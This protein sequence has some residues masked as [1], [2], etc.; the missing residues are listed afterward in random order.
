[1]ATWGNVG[2]ESALPGRGVRR[3]ARRERDLPRPVCQTLQVDIGRALGLVSGSLCVMTAAFEHKRAGVLARRVMQCADEPACVLVA[4]PKGQRL[5]TLI[6]DSHAF[7]LNVIDPTQRL[8]IKKFQPEEEGDQFDM[9]ETR[10]L[11]TGAPA[12]L[13]AV[14]ALDCEVMRHFDLEA[15]HEVYVGQVLAALV[16][17]KGIE[18]CHSGEP[19]PAAQT[20]PGANARVGNGHAHPGAASIPGHDA[21]GQPVAQHG[22]RHP[23]E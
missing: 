19:A 10:T 14:A 6:R 20:I 3:D 11:A 15:D 23:G 7:T 5:A 2:G 1:M 9:L 13:R 22:A 4:L 16:F 12:I 17:A 18:S 8:L 21:P